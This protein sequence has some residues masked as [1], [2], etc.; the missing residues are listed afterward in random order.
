M[1]REKQR[2]I[3]KWCGPKVEIGFWDVTN[4]R[5]IQTVKNIVRLHNLLIKIINLG[6]SFT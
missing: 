6:L 5:A 3:I 4:V 1:R 2:F